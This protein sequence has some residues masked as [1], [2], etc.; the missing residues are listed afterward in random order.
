MIEIRELD[1]RYIITII[2]NDYENFSFPIDKQSFRD[3]YETMRD[4]IGA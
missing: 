1:D 2:N 3:L 4:H